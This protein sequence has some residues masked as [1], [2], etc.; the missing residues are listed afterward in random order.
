MPE[1][2]R[3][4]PDGLSDAATELW[5]WVTGTF[6]LDE[7]EAALLREA[8][9]TVTTL[10]ELAV[11]IAEDGAT[12]AGSRGQTVAHPALT[13]ARQQRLALA[14]LLAALRLPEGEQEGRPQRRGGARGFYAVQGGAS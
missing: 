4:P 7:H 2:A 1:D 11:V 5:E 3:T 13:E 10:D 9:R 14:R 6:M 8:C 12:T